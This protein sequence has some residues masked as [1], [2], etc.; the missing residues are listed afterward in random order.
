MLAQGNAL[1]FGFARCALKERRNPPPV[2]GGT[3]TRTRSRGVAPGWNAPR[4][5]RVNLAEFSIG[6]NCYGPICETGSSTLS[7]QLP[8]MHNRAESAYTVASPL[9]RIA[10]EKFR[11]E[12]TL[13]SSVVETKVNRDSPDYEK[14]TRRLV[15]LVA[16]IKNQEIAIQQGG[17]TKA[18]ESQHKKGRL[19]ARERVALLIDPNTP[20][21]ELGIYAAYEMYEEWGGAPA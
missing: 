2:Q 3:C 18:I 20:F 15:D 11:E 7:S 6:E 13:T 5:W 17:G 10:A 4:P 21:F 12:P 9:R 14:N 16:E 19:T 8:A 1:G